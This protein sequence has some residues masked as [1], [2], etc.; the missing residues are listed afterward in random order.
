MHRAALYN[1]DHPGQNENC[2]KVK[3]TGLKSILFF[4]FWDSEY[5]LFF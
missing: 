2:T 1:L 4:L 5:N 3:K